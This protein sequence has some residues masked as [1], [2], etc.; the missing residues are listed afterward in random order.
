MNNLAL[1]LWEG[2]EVHHRGECQ[3]NSIDVAQMHLVAHFVADRPCKARGCQ[4]EG[5]SSVSA[6]AS[7]GQGEGLAGAWVAAGESQRWRPSTV[8]AA[9]GW[10][11]AH[12][13][14]KCISKDRRAYDGIG[15][16]VCD[17]QRESREV[18]AV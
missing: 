3:C 15:A 13:L 5:E 10:I 16:G 12:S 2:L 6:V 14:L 1:A 9:H 17:G 11:G 4:A 8:K 7:S 18:A